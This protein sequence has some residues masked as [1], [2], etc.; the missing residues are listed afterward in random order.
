MFVV[1]EVIRKTFNHMQETCRK[2]DMD[3]FLPKGGELTRHQ[4]IRLAAAGPDAAGQMI[5][6][7]RQ[8][9]PCRRMGG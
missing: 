4:A 3:G 1:S 5:Q 8:D 7:R 2:R 9:C 6:K